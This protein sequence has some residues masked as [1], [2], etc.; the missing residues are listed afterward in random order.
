[1]LY[2]WCSSPLVNMFVKR[3]LCIFFLV[4]SV[5][6]QHC[7]EAWWP[8]TARPACPGTA[9]THIWTCAGTSVT[10]KYREPSRI[11][12]IIDVRQKTYHEELAFL[13]IS[14][15]NI[16]LTKVC[17]IE[18]IEQMKERWCFCYLKN[19]NILKPYIIILFTMFI[20]RHLHVNVNVSLIFQTQHLPMTTLLRELAAP[21]RSLNP[22]PCNSIHKGRTWADCATPLL[23]ITFPCFRM[24]A[25]IAMWRHYM[26]APLI[27]LPGCR[28][29]PFTLPTMLATILCWYAVK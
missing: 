2:L 7:Y 19:G 14:K 24:D 9:T 25:V 15:I 28:S 5:G 11:C 12:Y 29:R 3:L 18:Q 27:K 21:S 26:Q 17:I 20:C 10:R 6:K 8:K 13:S 1:M 16:F 4:T 23:P 22:F